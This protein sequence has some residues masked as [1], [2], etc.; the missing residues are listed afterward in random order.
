MVMVKKPIR[1]YFKK[2]QIFWINVLCFDVDVIDEIFQTGKIN[3]F[4]ILRLT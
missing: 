1:K 2:N 4:S 3:N